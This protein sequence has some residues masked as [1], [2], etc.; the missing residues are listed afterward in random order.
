MTSR[1]A[2]AKLLR[3]AD[4][5]FRTLDLCNPG[6]KYPQGF[7]DIEK[8]SVKLSLKAQTIFYNLFK[9]EIKIFHEALP[10]DSLFISEK[11]YFF[12]IFCDPVH[13][14]FGGIAISNQSLQELAE[15]FFGG[16]GLTQQTKR[17]MSQT[18]IRLAQ[19]IFSQL[20]NA[21]ES[22]S[23]PWSDR[24]LLLT[25]E[26]SLHPGYYYQSRLQI[27]MEGCSSSIILY[28]PASLLEPSPLPQSDHSIQQQHSEQL[29]QIPFRLTSVLLQKKLNL[30]ELSNLKEGDLIV[31]DAPG[32]VDVYCHQTP[33]F[34]ARVV[35]DAGRQA[36]QVTETLNDG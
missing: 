19:R 5:Q 31:T 3:Q 21:I 7:A 23:P 30:S 2:Y 17:E 20:L 35:T 12:R 22:L 10:C 1:I 11:D 29:Q 28:W 6:E 18:E 8:L 4:K 25:D 9:K 32:Q 27:E 33:L 36:L 24:K 15:I 16:A 13:K 26:N 34:K 14:S